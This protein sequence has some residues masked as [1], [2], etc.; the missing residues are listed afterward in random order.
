MRNS[1][2]LLCP[3]LVAVAAFGDGVRGTLAGTVVDPDG[4]TVADAPVQARNVETGQMYKTDRTPGGNFILSDLPA[5]T[6]DISV[7]I[8]GLNPYQRKGVI[9]EPLKTAQLDIRLQY[10][11]QLSTLGEDPKSIAADLRKHVPPTGAVPR[12]AEGKPDLSGIWWSPVDVDPGKP[13]FLP[14]AL[15]VAKR[16]MEDN[17]KDSPQSHCLPAAVLRLGPVYELVQSR[18]LLVIISDDDYPG[19]HQVYLD[20]RAHPADVNPGWYGHNVGHW[21]GDVLVVD[22]VGFDSRVWLDQGGR[23]HSDKLHVIE[24]Y[25]RPDFGHLETTITVEDPGILAKP[26]TMVRMSDLAP[27]EEIHEFICNENERDAPHLLGK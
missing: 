3:L 22:R 27:T 10:S 9:V 21:E 20:G 15:E 14:R 8:P 24:R 18:D 23:P 6:Y 13:E 17:R 11:S 5:G 12:T 4:K 2:L 19:F 16:R 26:Y 25:R 7:A 1:A